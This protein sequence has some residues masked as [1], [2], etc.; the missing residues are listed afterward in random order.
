MQRIPLIRNLNEI[1]ITNS[2][3]PTAPIESAVGELRVSDDLAAQ[4]SALVRSGKAI[5]LEFLAQERP[6]GFFLMFG[7]LSSPR[8]AVVTTADPDPG[9]TISNNVGGEPK[10]EI[11]LP[12]VTEAHDE[13]LKIGVDGDA[14]PPQGDIS[15][16][17]T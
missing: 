11:K 3:D 12:A 15:A 9:V 4:I 16:D 5:T 13:A 7:A 17:P 1:D 10:P 6:D 8:V 14:A 2:Q